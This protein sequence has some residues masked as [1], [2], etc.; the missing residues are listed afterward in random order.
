ML[1]CEARNHP[2]SKNEVSSLED[3]IR[4]LEKKLGSHKEKIDEL[5][6]TARNDLKDMLR[7]YRSEYEERDLRIDALR[8]DLSTVLEGLHVIENNVMIKTILGRTR[9][10]LPP[11]DERSR[12]LHDCHDEVQN[13]VCNCEDLLVRSVPGLVQEP[14]I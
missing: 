11:F 9:I 3:K 5:R 14:D 7:K 13:F 2:E 6:I 8:V 4:N 1:F 10:L 12:F